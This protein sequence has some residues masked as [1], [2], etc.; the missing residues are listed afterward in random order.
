M[1]RCLLLCSARPQP[2]QPAVAVIR[3]PTKERCD[4]EKKLQRFSPLCWLP[5][6]VNPLSPFTAAAAN[7]PHLCGQVFADQAAAVIYGLTKESLEMTSRTRNER[8]S[9]V[10]CSCPQVVQS[11]HFFFPKKYNSWIC[12]VLSKSS[13][14]RAHTFPPRPPRSRVRSINLVI[15]LRGAAAAAAAAAAVYQQSTTTRPTAALHFVG[16]IR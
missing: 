16:L 3:T 1:T 14:I 7:L 2:A 11:S 5:P 15:V 10:M 8:A 13:N 9:H 4:N 12:P 6:A